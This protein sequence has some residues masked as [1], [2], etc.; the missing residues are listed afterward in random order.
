MIYEVYMVQAI[1]YLSLA[2]RIGINQHSQNLNARIF[3][4]GN[5]KANCDLCESYN[6]SIAVMQEIRRRGLKVAVAGIPKTID[7]D[8]PVILMPALNMPDCC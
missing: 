3:V 1:C 4:I 5:R 6:I 2:T 7:N 8:I